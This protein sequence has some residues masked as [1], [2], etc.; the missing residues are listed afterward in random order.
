MDR[1]RESRQTS[2][3][4]IDRV[5]A[6]LG[7]MAGVGALAAGTRLAALPQA[8]RCGKDVAIIRRGR[9][10]AREGRE[11]GDLR[12][13]PGRENSTHDP[14]GFMPMPE[15]EMGLQGSPA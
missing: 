15:G 11:P 3:L 10:A 4:I 5:G 2:N 13:R 14:A 1:R 9:P 12:A 8:V 7:G 6:I